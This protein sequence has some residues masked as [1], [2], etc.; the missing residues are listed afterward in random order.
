MNVHPLAPDCAI[1]SRFQEIVNAAPQAAAILDGAARISYASLDAWSNQIAV[2]LAG[3]KPGSPVALLS[4]H[5]PATVAAMLGALKAGQIYCVV[6]PA[7]PATRLDH[8]LADLQADLVLADG[9]HAALA[10]RVAQPHAAVLEIDSLGEAAMPRALPP[11]PQPATLAAIYYSSGTTGRPKG[12]LRDHAALVYRAWLDTEV[13]QI[14]PGDRVGW[15]YSAAYSASVADIFGALLTGATLCVFPPERQ[16]GGAL[17]QW[18]EQEQINS[19]HLHA[20]ILRQLLDMTP[21]TQIFQHLRYVRPSDRVAVV[22]L[23]RLRQRLP[24]TAV[25]V[26]TL[27]SSETGPVCRFICAHDTPLDGDTVPVG[28]PVAAAQVSLIDEDG[29]IVEGEGVGEI[30]VRSRYLSQGYWRQPELTAQRFE[31]DPVDPRYGSY[32]MGDLARR[33]PDGMLELVGR[34]DRRVKIRGY[35]VALDDVEAALTAQP[36]ILEAAVSAR[37]GADGANQII[38][39]VVADTAAPRLRE[40]LAAQ[41]PAYM[42]PARFVFLPTLPRQPNGKVDSRALPA[43]GAARPALATAYV[44]PRTALEQQIAAI[45]GE[46]LALES[47]GVEDNFLDLGGNSLQAMR[48]VNR[49]AALTPTDIPPSSLFA[50]PTVAAQTLEVTKRQLADLAAHDLAGLMSEVT[51]LQQDLHP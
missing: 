23:R 24:A 30:V 22:D 29:Q 51:N 8:I 3:R 14:G 11:P 36:G 44:A 32:R 5:G 34:K 21:A 13:V 49:V 39:Y 35:T 10:E 15:L 18:L 47:V 4:G 1:P 17:A 25:I 43:P 50:A 16:G 12:V 19:L 28:F 48:I 31:I 20:T 42:L 6:D 38:A 9:S 27:G 2:A 40:A 46:V 33:R 37:A 26:H 7:M 45:W 41:L